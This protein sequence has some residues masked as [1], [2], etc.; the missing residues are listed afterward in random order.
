MGSINS[1][2]FSSGSCTVVYFTGALPDFR[3]ITKLRHVFCLS[4][5][6]HGCFRG[7]PH[8]CSPTTIPSSLPI[9]N[10]ISLRG[11]YLSHG[12]D[13][14]LDIRQPQ[15]LLSS[16]LPT[17]TIFPRPI[18]SGAVI[19]FL[20]L[21]SHRCL[22]TGRHLSVNLSPFRDSMTRSRHPFGT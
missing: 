1:R 12:V 2:Y 17:A 21:G 14:L 7:H 15:S 18:S 19:N 22:H 8:P 13:I 6:T 16:A 20:C 10:L 9:S 4:S 5:K 11:S 3:S